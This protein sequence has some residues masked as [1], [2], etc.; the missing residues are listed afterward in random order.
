MK[1]YARAGLQHRLV[2]IILA[3]LIATLGTAC[4][5]KRALYLPDSEDQV[6]QQ[7]PEDEKSQR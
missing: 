6:Q 3:C 1:T 2:Q 4:G 5:Q 7:M